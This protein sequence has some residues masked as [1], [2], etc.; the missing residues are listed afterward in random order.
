MKNPSEDSIARAEPAK[1][2]GDNLNLT[3]W[4]GRKHITIHVHGDDSRSRLPRAT[5]DWI[6]ADAV[7]A[8]MPI[9]RFF[10]DLVSRLVVAKAKAV[11]S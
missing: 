10:T 5:S 2:S 4:I 1:L 3:L 9:G 6:K 11:A 8:G 7:S